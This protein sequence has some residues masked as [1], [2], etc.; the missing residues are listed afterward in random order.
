MNFL[1]AFWKNRRLEK[2][3][4]GLCLTFRRGRKIQKNT[5]THTLKSVIDVGQGMNVWLGKFGKKAK[6]NIPK[7]NKDRTFNNTI[8]QASK[9]VEMRVEMGKLKKIYNVSV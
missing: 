2:K 4:K 7:F 8:E 5:I 6:Q 3:H 9:R 1:F